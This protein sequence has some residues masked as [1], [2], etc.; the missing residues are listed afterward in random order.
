[1]M[2]V[3]RRID[4]LAPPFSGH[5][6]PILG[7]ARMAQQYYDVRVLSTEA[8]VERIR[9]AGLEAVPLMRGADHLLDRITNPPYAVRSNPLRLYRQ[10]QEAAKLL[11]QLGT[12]IGDLY[13]REAPQLLIADYTLPAAGLAAQRAGVS[14]WTS[15]PSPC[16]LET[17]DGPPAYFGG[18]S[19][20]RSPVGRWRD[21]CGR[22][23]VRFFKQ[24]IFRM[25]GR[26]LRSAGISSPYRTDGSEAV[27]SPEKILALGLPELEFPRQWPKTV[28]FVGPML[29]T[30]PNSGVEPEFREGHRHV[31]ISLGT[32]LAWC[33]DEFATRMSGVANSLSDVVFH[34]SDGAPDAPYA[35]SRSNFQRL[36]FVD[37]GRWL[38]R[39]DL[40]IHHGGAGIMYYCIA[41]AKP[42][43]VYPVDY[44][45]FDHAARLV[46]ANLAVRVGRSSNL[47]KVLSHTLTGTELTQQCRRFQSILD[48]SVAKQEFMA[49]LRSRLSG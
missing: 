6:H 26:S 17:P 48:R 29:Y 43:L 36:P 40:V 45:Q 23:L 49:A 38:S 4:F 16:V 11:G 21:A 20:A 46:H 33:K 37:Y 22:R 5:L 12:E 44:D 10:F 13:R 2:V 34:F 30:P 28:Q 39:Y 27:Y 41:H 9:A 47:A 25:H 18:L 14:W 7:M 31:L 35:R 3:R 15:L 24:G 19:I 1:M 42:S 8:G 32:H